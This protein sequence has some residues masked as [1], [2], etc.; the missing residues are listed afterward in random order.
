MTKNSGQVVDRTAE[1]VAIFDK[2][3]ESG[4]SP[5]KPMR[6]MTEEDAIALADRVV[7][8][9]MEEYKDLLK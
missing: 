5:N 9:T 7:K 3:L 2:E 6:A 1:M 8:R 4:F